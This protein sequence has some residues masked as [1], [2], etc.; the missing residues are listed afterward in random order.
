MEAPQVLPRNKRLRVY[1]MEV[2]PDR[3]RIK[4][5][6]RRPKSRPRCGPVSTLAS[7]YY[8]EEFEYD[9]SRVLRAGRDAQSDDDDEEEEEDWGN[10]DGWGDVEEDGGG[11][12]ADDGSEFSRE[13]S[14]AV[15]EIGWA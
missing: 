3:R 9:D 13:E 2:D 12:G 4:L 10:D 15:A 11:V 1:A 8:L 5:T 6:C 14:N 7:D